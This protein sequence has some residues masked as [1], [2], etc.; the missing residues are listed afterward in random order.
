[1]TTLETISKIRNI[2]IV[3]H[4]DA[5]KTT[6]TER[7]LYYT[8]KAYK[9]GEV[10]EGTAVMDWMV[11][12]QERGIT[13]TSAATKC[14]WRD[15][16]VNIIDT[17]GHVDFT[18]EV[19]RSLRVLDGAVVVFCAV[20][21]VQPQSETVWRQ[22]NRYK[23]PRI[24]FVNKMDRTGASFEKV[25]QQIADRLASKPL[26]IVLPLGAEENFVG[27]IDLLTMK[28]HLWD[29]ESQKTLGA[30]FKTIDVP[31]EYLERAKVARD[32]MIETLS[33]YNDEILELYL[34]DKE[35]PFDLL[36]KTLRQATIEN[37]VI[38]VLC[39]SSLRNKGVQALLD[40]VTYY[41]PSPLDIP[42]TVAYMP[43]T[44]EEVAIKT[45]PAGEFAAL[46][47]KIA[48]DPHVGKI[49]Y[50]R[51]YSGSVESGKVVYNVTRDGRKERI[52][53]LLQMH[54]NQRQDLT[55]AAAGDIV[56]AVGLKNIATGDSLASS[57]DRPTLEKITFPETVISV[58]I[59]PKTQGELSRLTEV[60]EALMNEDPT[61]K[62]KI[63]SETGETLIS[64]MGE[65]HLEVIVDRIIREFNVKASVGKPQ[66][67][68]KEGITAAG[69]GESLY[70]R[71]IGG[72]NQFAQV[73]VEVSPLERGQGFK[74]VSQL[75]FGTLPALFATAIEKGCNDAMNDGIL[76]GFPV[77][78]VMVKLTSAMYRETE[79]NEIAFKI[80]TYEAMKAAMRSA[81]PVIL[82]PFMKVEIETPE[83]Y[84][85]DIIGNMNSRRGKVI[86]MEM[87]E[88]IRVIDCH[89]PLSD[90]F[91]YS[92]QL[93]S[94]SQGRATFTMELLHY[95]EAPKSVT[96]RILGVFGYGQAPQQMMAG[97]N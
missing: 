90:M 10:H 97:D 84:V 29:E 96:E 14:H 86:N 65:L 15:C 93:R 95:D 23:V 81:R 17:P 37:R 79:S 8:G 92:T 40:A 72:K 82:E 66:V 55:V 49:A 71:Q 73:S 78:D 44:H 18:A 43:V 35:I 2:G 70:E 56:A 58:A 59:E 4:I 22:A 41:L 51:I 38:P 25:V 13:I 27:H 32:V 33:A 19:E 34:E 60:L 62:A 75:A 11:Q 1:M 87:R 91:G 74:F 12:E 42:P 52:G 67:A 3:A 39:G 47:F 88:D 85:G 76:A 50:L 21:G 26:P 9:M 69:K 46:V 63:D 36:Q 6:T 61:F 48:T 16:D 54:A 30:E 68:Y 24:A 77:V 64:G 53:R 89:A 80:A 57:T 5:G 45:D 7:I 20:A 83:S 94:L 28:E 31:V